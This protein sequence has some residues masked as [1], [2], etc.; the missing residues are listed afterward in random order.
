MRPHTDLFLRSIPEVQVPAV[1]PSVLDR[2]AARAAKEEEESE[3]EPTQ[4]DPQTTPTGRPLGISP[5]GDA[6]PLVPSVHSGDAQEMRDD[7]MHDDN[8]ETKGKLTN[9]DANDDQKDA[10][11]KGALENEHHSSPVETPDAE[12]VPTTA[13]GDQQQD[14]VQ[15]AKADEQNEVEEPAQGAEPVAEEKAGDDSSIGKGLNKN[16]KSPKKDKK[17]KEKKDKGGDV[18][19]EKNSKKNQLKSDKDAAGAAPAAGRPNK[20]KEVP[21]SKDLSSMFAKKQKTS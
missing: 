8:D 14:E 7:A 15:Q 2:A 5:L 18:E 6:A 9:D 16:N 13:M 21:A 19:K 3:P 17:S 11:Q 10:Q 20:K 12:E 4:T 1:I